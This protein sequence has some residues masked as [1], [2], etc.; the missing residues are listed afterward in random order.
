[1][2]ELQG[3]PTK[4]LMVLEL[5]QASGEFRYKEPNQSSISVKNED[6]HGKARQELQAGT[7]E[8]SSNGLPK[9]PRGL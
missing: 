9:T 3:A 6:R 4:L 5:A 8:S 7:M 1:M 2:G